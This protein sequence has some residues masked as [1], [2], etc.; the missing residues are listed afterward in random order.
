MLHDVAVALCDAAPPFELGVVC[1]VFGTDRTAD[2]LPGF[3]FAVCAAEPPPLWSTSGFRIDTDHGLERLETADLIAVPGWHHIDR[4]PPEPLLEALR[5]AVARGARVM[6]VCSGAFVLAAAGLLEGRRATTHWRLAATLKAMYPHV[7]VDPGVLYIDEGQV[8]TS[9]GTAAGIDLCLH[10]V[11][12]EFGAGVANA[13][14]RRMVVPPH[15]DGGQAQYIETP[16]PDP[17][18]ATDMAA[19]CAWAQQ[20][21][22]DPLPVAELARRFHMSPRNFARRF[23]AATGTTPHRWILQQRCD[24]AQRLLEETG[25]DLE[26]V[27]RRTGFGDAASLRLHFTRRRGTSPQRYRQTFRSRVA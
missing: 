13:I 12:R 21:L 6:S 11:R 9:A 2:G 3:D 15:R 14:A 18:P 10:I 19:V 17:R 5:R 25:D 1:E 4:H 23:A 22:A 16:L 7:L 20:H 26:E 24:L 8:L 27:A